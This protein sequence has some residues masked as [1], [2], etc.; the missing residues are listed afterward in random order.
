MTTKVNIRDA[1]GK[2][3]CRVVKSSKSNDMGD[4]SSVKCQT[5][6]DYLKEQWARYCGL[7]EEILGV[8][9]ESCIDQQHALF[10]PIEAGYIDA[11]S[12]LTTLKRNAL[13]RENPTHVDG[14]QG[15]SSNSNQLNVVATP[16]SYLSKI[17]LPIFD[18][19]YI[20]WQGFCDLF[21]ALVH[22]N[23]NLTAIEKFHYL[24]TSITGEAANLIAHITISNENYDVA[25]ASLQNRYTNSRVIITML[26]DK[27]FA[28]PNSSETAESIK[29]LLDCTGQSLRMLENLKRPIK[30][31]DDVI[32]YHIAAKLPNET[33]K[34]WESS[35]SISTDPITWQQL[36]TFLLGR[37]RTLEATASCLASSNTSLQKSNIKPG[38]RNTHATRIGQREPLSCQLCSENHY[39]SR[40]I[41]FLNHSILDRYEIVKKYNLCINCFQTGHTEQK[42]GSKYRCRYCS[43]CHHS[44][45]HSNMSPQ[46]QP[47]VSVNVTQARCSTVLLATAQVYAACND[48]RLHKLTVLLDQGSETSLITERAAQ[49]LRLPRENSNLHIST[50][51][52]GKSMKTNGMV[53]V[54]LTS[55]HSNAPIVKV[56]AFVLSSITNQLPIQRIKSLVPSNIPRPLADPE[57]HTPKAIDMLI[58]SDVYCYIINTGMMKFNDERLLAQN[59]IFGWILTGQ[60]HSGEKKVLNNATSFHVKV[61]T[62][63]NIDQ[64]LRQFWEIADVGHQDHHH[65]IQDAAVEQH[66]AETYQ[67]LH[68]GRYQVRLP[69]TTL[70][71]SP[72]VNFGESFKKAKYQFFQVERRLDRNQ[73]LRQQ[74]C[75]FMDEYLRLGHMSLILNNDIEKPSD[76]CLYLPHHAVIKEASSTTKLRVVFNA[77]SQTASGMSL[78]K[79][80][81]TGP[82]LQPELTTILLR[83]RNH[84]IAL[85]ADIEKMYRQI[86][87]HPDDREFQRIV[88]RRESNK[89][90]CHF[91]LNTV[92]YGTSAAPY[93]AV[94]TLQ[95]L[96]KDEAHTF[97][98]A[99]SIALN[100]FYVDDLISGAEDVASA[101][102]IQTEII[103]LMHAGGMKLRKWSSNEDELLSQIPSSDRECQFPLSIHQND[104]VKAL[105][106]KWNPT[107]DRLSFDFKFLMSEKKCTTKRQ[108]LSISSRLFDPIGLLAPVTLV[109]KLLFQKLWLL[110]IDW[111]D[112]LPDDIVTE[113]L[114]YVNQI[115]SLSSIS[116][117]RWTGYIPTQSHQLQLHGFSDASKAAY[118]AAVYLRIEH[119]DG[120]CLTTLL[121]A[122]TKVAPLT[123][124][125]LPRLELCGAALLSNLMKSLMEKLF[126]SIPI[127]TVMWCDSAITLAWLQAPPSKWKV[128]VANKTSQILSNLPSCQFR[129]VK[130]ADN[131]ADIASR[132]IDPTKIQTH[133]LWWSGPAW[134]SNDSNDWPHR[135]P[136]LL[137]RVDLEA[138]KTSA[139]AH[140]TIAE[141]GRPLSSCSTL[142]KLLRVT[143]YCRR[144]MANMLRS[145]SKPCVSTNLSNHLSSRELQDA[146]MFWISQAQ[147]DAFSDDMQRL[148][149][150]K[151]VV[152]NSVLISLQPFIDEDGILRVYGRLRRSALHYH[153]RHPIILPKH[154]H[155]TKL[156]VSHAHAQTQHGDIQLMLNFIRQNY[157]ILNARSLVKW[158]IKNCH[159]CHRL[160][161]KPANQLMADLPK[162]RITPSR[163]FSRVSIDYAG[164]ITLRVVRGRGRI[165]STKGYISVFVCQATKAVHLEAVT[166]LTADAFLSAFRRFIS[167]RGGCSEIVS[168][169]GTNFVGAAKV[170]R[171]FHNAA[172]SAYPQLAA[173]NVNWRFNP[174][175]APHFNGLAEAAV[176]SMKK[177][178]IRI[179]GNTTLTYEELSTVLTQIE[180][181]LNS[182]PLCRLMDD[183]SQVEVLT[184]GHFLIGGPLLAP[185]EP[186]YVEEKTITN[187]WRR[188]QQ[189]CQQIWK[190]WSTEYLAELQKRTKW[191]SRQ[192]EPAVGDL[193]Y[194][195]DENLPPL[196][197][198]RGIITKLH[199][200][201]DGLS[202]VVTV[203]TA[204]RSDML[205]P[206]V[207]LCWVP[208]HQ[209]EKTQ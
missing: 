51:G 190:C 129:Y 44:L 141:T 98:R 15:N 81:L 57:W 102:E 125:T 58:G 55:I 206:V 64:L 203:R 172:R 204:S 80:L 72:A 76:Q 179:V 149:A 199:P 50:V 161:A 68:D 135:Q 46:E 6:I 73:E 4:E 201:K 83:W 185:I 106:I 142:T 122:R 18:S 178:F 54:A 196:R 8:T 16:P 59:T 30:H 35:I 112:N 41:T 103:Q 32:V 111:D 42:C 13:Q 194:V 38:S 21:T 118:A 47:T 139:V 5:M 105:G 88:W 159:V 171:Q 208:V 157:W 193:V 186:N 198:P 7:H 95:Q 94:K 165:S 77:S 11:M 92:T 39:L 43:E 124:I 40:C 66:Y 97:P 173:L 56:N 70:V 85:C 128:F 163:P 113:W 205:R 115:N 79:S 158:V 75:E 25:W 145:I 12:R 19:G 138:R 71:A 67:R 53:Q 150:E 154:H 153:H 116:I 86:L 31:W 160:K 155:V 169:C 62:T 22:T 108:L 187:H 181:C 110:K 23:T 90:L 24:K 120:T 29:A 168:D 133:P 101:R 33:R 174:P 20:E 121:A 140:V 27:L 60:F 146:L 134:L 166:E 164:P 69:F 130:S 1:A 104:T 28:Q 184:P 151:Q 207:K 188:L 177:H 175:A 126:A 10:E 84:K 89:P 117:P 202:R 137:G 65:S 191:Q 17:V 78:N 61:I 100:D 136:H 26:L 34:A 52:S 127:R 147:I 93:L 119:S 63:E 123:P 180:A 131:P 156:I 3:I 183:P 197:W 74:Y 195:I 114:R 176:R 99:S 82:T 144:F 49:L 170:L 109:P 167:R 200:G 152:N 91:R 48:G 107:T 192:P 132:G 9:G 209:D 148:T 36:E 182:R 162:S 87:V 2:A 14:N 189:M 37:F 143:A 96:A 45:L